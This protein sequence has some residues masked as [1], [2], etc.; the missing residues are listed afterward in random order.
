MSIV[1]NADLL[2]LTKD[3]LDSETIK[4]LRTIEETAMQIRE[5]IQSLVRIIKPVTIDY[6][7]GGKMLDIKKS[8]KQEKKEQE[9]EDLEG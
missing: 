4:R 9:E 2:L 6:P 3:K 8:E 5:I 1:G 7:S